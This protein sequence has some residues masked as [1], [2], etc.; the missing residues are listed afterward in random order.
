MRI[1]GIILT[2]ERDRPYPFEGKIKR[3]VSLGIEGPYS[4]LKLLII[5]TFWILDSDS[6]A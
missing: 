4:Y 3:F 5:T 1:G 6:Y 2:R